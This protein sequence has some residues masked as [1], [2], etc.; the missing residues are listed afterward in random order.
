[1]AAATIVFK[2]ASF[3]TMPVKVALPLFFSPTLSEMA[4]A[5]KGKRAF[6]PPFFAYMP[7]VVMSP[8]GIVIFLAFAPRKQRW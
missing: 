8:Y 3:S 6:S 1:M 7:T 2:Q 4:G 5:A